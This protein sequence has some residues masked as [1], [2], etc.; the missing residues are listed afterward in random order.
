MNK[1][2]HDDARKKYKA[3]EK[4]FTKIFLL[5]LSLIGL[6]FISLHTLSIGDTN[7][8]SSNLSYKVYDDRIYIM[9]VH[10]GKFQAL[11]DLNGKPYTIERFCEENSKHTICSK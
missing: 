6:V 11:L 7:I 9:H 4:S 3:E 2:V 8:K 1:Q 10:N 5:F